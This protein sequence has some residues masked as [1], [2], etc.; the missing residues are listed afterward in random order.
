MRIPPEDRHANLIAQMT[1]TTPSATREHLESLRLQ[2]LAQSVF[3]EQGG[4]SRTFW[5]LTDVG[6]SHV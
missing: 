1:D 3:K 4:K 2:G 6:K 5:E